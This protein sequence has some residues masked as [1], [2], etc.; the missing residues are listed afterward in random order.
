MLSRNSLR[1]LLC[2][3]L[4][5]A[6]LLSSSAFAQAVK[7]TFLPAITASA[8]PEPARFLA[9]GEVM[10]M[11]LEVFA[12]GGERLYD[13]DFKD[14][15]LFDWKWQDQQG[16]RLADGAYRCLLTIKDAAGRESQR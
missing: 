1:S 12:L 7:S 5:L 14:G 2:A 16:Q 8:A 9:N 10:R 4:W 11:R 3:G 13:S 6:C 15:N